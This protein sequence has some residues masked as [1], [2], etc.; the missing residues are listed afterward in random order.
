M[1]LGSNIYLGGGGLWT[2]SS[3]RD[4][5]KGAF[6][7]FAQVGKRFHVGKA[8]RFSLFAFRYLAAGTDRRNG[9]REVSGTLRLPFSKRA[10]LEQSYGFSMF[11]GT[12]NPVDKRVGFDARWTLSYEV[13]RSRRQ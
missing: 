5:T 4:Y 3:V 9:Y 12:D 10:V 8:D 6:H 2:I 13:F 7:P 1:G 11:H